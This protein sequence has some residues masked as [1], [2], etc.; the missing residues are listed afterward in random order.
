MAAISTPLVSSL[1]AKIIG[2]YQDIHFVLGEDFAWSFAAETI[3]HPEIKTLDELRQLLHEIGHATLKH[4]SYS[5]DAELIDMEREAWRY[6]YEM[7]APRYGIG[8]S[9]DDN[10]VQESL[11]SY[12]QWLHARSRCPRCQAV[13][14]EISMRS[15]RCLHCQRQWSVNEARLCRLKRMSIKN[16]PAE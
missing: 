5:H 11:D 3:T 13:G 1:V 9:A 2:D 7:L 8:L 16:N 14:I 4:S 15:Y 12:R 6:A 10:I